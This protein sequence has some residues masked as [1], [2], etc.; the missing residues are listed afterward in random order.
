MFPFFAL[1]A[2]GG[3]LALL[4][5]A[6][7]TAG[8]GRNLVARVAAGEQ[9][10]APA[11]ELEVVWGRTQFWPRAA[12]STVSDGRLALSEI[13]GRPVILNFWASWCIPCQEEAPILS[14]SARAHADQV[15]FLGVDVQDLRSDALAF[16]REFEVP[17]VSV[18]DRGN[19]TYE[20]YGLSGVPETYY[21][22][23]RLRVVAHTQG[24]VTRQTLEAG[25]A[26][27][28]GVRK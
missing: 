4:G 13:R 10:Y 12:R 5:W 21:L 8:E 7:F 3:L 9:P 17:Y 23:R 6:T 24:P 28:E 14:A 1:A 11:F 25:I 20:A 19:K 2:V 16:L 18:R 15:V 26:S 27:A 22:D